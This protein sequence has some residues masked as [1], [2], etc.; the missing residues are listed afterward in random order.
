[1]FLLNPDPTKI[2]VSD[3]RALIDNE[4]IESR[5]IEYKRIVAVGPRAD[6]RKKIKLLAGISSFANTDGGEFHRRR[7]S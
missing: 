3:L 2:T 1:M 4:V 6:E 5:D 7:T